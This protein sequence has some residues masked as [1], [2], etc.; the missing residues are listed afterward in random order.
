MTEELE[1]FGEDKLVYLKGMFDVFPAGLPPAELSVELST[2]TK[3]DDWDHHFHFI[4]SRPV[5]AQKKKK[6]KK[7]SHDSSIQ[8]F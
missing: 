1:L 4:V 2:K 7:K 6:K 8:Y 5:S 3:G